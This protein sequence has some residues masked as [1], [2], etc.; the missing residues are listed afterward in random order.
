MHHYG[1]VMTRI[2][3]RLREP[4]LFVSNETGGSW[5]D[6]DLI[7][8]LHNGEVN[9]NTPGVDTVDKGSLNVAFRATH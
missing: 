7:R 5:S 4:L 1:A 2:C 9:L 6:N 3:W 8:T